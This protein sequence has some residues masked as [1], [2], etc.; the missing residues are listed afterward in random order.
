MK[1][2]NSNTATATLSLVSASRFAGLPEID[3]G[4]AAANQDQVHTVPVVETQANQRPE[5][6]GGDD[7]AGRLPKFIQLADLSLADRVSFQNMAQEDEDFHRQTAIDNA[8]AEASS[9]EFARAAF[10]KIGSLTPA[11]Q[12]L[13]VTFQLD[14]GFHSGTCKAYEFASDVEMTIE[15]LKKYAGKHYAPL[16]GY[17]KD[18]DN[19]IPTKAH[20]AEVWYE[21]GK[22]MRVFRE[23]VME[24]TSQLDDPNSPVYNRYHRMSRQMVKPDMTATRAD[25]AILDEHL[26]LMT[27][28]C[29]VTCEYFLDWLA[30]HLQFPDSKPLTAMVSIS[31]KKGTGKSWFHLI[32]RWLLGPNLVSFTGGD[33]LYSTFDDVYVQKR[34]VFFDE[35]PRPSAMRNKGDPMAKLKRFITSPRTTLR[36]MHKPSKEMRVG[37]IF[38]TCN[39]VEALADFTS[40][41]ERRFCIMLC[42]EEKRPVDYYRRLFAWSGDEDTPGP[43][44]AKLAGYL[45]QRDLSRFN[46]KGEPPRTAA[47]AYVQQANISDEAKFLRELVAEGSPPFDKDLGRVQ[48]LLNQLETLFKPAVLKGLNFTTRSLPSALREIGGKQLGV[49]GKRKATNSTYTAWCWRNFDAWDDRKPAAFIEYLETGEVPGEGDDD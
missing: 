3:F 12:A 29:T 11:S 39:E 16:C 24:P 27:G 41:E 38:I 20:L 14:M 42:L 23:V 26:V 21:R 1:H 44:M 22:D 36:P 8:R 15:A 35:M 32:M 31:P 28:G 5:A 47:R 48:G 17:R 37:T 6:P 45:M 33:E 30:Y 49:D 43:G 13:L 2:Y 4:G 19:L 10:G 40:E 46:P 7:T 34:N 25:I 9:P 18:G